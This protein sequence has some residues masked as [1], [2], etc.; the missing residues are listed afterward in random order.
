MAFKAFYSLGLIGFCWAGAGCEQKVR[1]KQLATTPPTQKPLK[2]STVAARPAHET[3]PLDSLT[4]TAQVQRFFQRQSPYSQHLKVTDLLPQPCEELVCAGQATGRGWALADFDQ[5]GRTD[6]LVTV[7][8]TLSSPGSITTAC[9]LN[10]RSQP[11]ERIRLNKW[12]SLCNQAYVVPVPGTSQP[13]IRY[14]RFVEAD[15]FAKQRV[16]ACQVDT[17]LWLTKGFVEYNRAPQDY[18]VT[19]IRYSTTQCYGMCPV[20]DLAIDQHGA[21]SYDARQYNKRKGR[22]AATIAPQSLQ[23]LWEALNYFDFPRLRDH[24]AV[25]ATDHPTCTLTIRYG[26]GQ[27]K[28]IEDYGEE[29]TFGLQRVYRLLFDLR[30]S[31]KWHRASSDPAAPSSP[32]RQPTPPAPSP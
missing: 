19:S 17:L 21:A 32:P 14:A 20:F 6:L 25:P 31:Q 4:T 26:N 10:K 11:Y 5:D 22:F 28:T 27:V 29:G 2:I 1:D 24:Y 7:R 23:E 16:I 30:E 18:L 12:L 15:P 9:F 13:A 3:T 8:D